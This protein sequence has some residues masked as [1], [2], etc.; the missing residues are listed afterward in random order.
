[1]IPLRPDRSA[2]CLAP[3]R[4]EHAK[5]AAISPRGHGSFLA[6]GLL[7]L[8]ALALP[9][10]GSRL[11]D[12]TAQPMASRTVQVAVVRTPPPVRMTAAFEPVDAR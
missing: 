4:I 10:L 12:R 6:R 3:M 9:V 5:G 1:M 8:A 2:S 11:A 7:V